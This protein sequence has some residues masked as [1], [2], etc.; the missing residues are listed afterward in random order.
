MADN[1]NKSLWEVVAGIWNEEPSVL[2]G[3]TGPHA[4]PGSA[5]FENVLKKTA[6]AL[7]KVGESVSAVHRNLVDH[8]NNT[9]HQNVTTALA[10][11]E[12]A[13]KLM[14]GAE[15]LMRG[16]HNEAKGNKDA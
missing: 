11:L 4:E 10:K 13:H 2:A 6:H 12:E 5:E 8:R 16:T 1:K 15:A 3:P 7:S 14:L 9:T